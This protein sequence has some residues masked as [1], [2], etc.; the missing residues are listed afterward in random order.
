MYLADVRH[1]IIQWTILYLV[2]KDGNPYT[3]QD[4]PN[5]YISPTVAIADPSISEDAHDMGRYYNPETVAYVA[6]NP[7]LRAL[8]LKKND[9][10]K[11]RLEMIRETL[12]RPLMTLL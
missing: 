2:D 3:Q 8:G 6:S 4:A 9:R 11:S 7:A 12:S 5:A 10:V 1:I